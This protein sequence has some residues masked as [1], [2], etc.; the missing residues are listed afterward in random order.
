MADI[1]A[2]RTVIVRDGLRYKKRTQVRSRGGHV[3][4]FSRMVAEA[5]G[6]KTAHRYVRRRYKEERRAEKLFQF[7]LTRDD[8]ILITEAG[9][10]LTYIKVYN[11]SNV[12][13]SITTPEYN[14]NSE[15]WSFN[16][17]DSADADKNGYWVDYLCEDGISTQY[18]Y[19]YKSADKNQE[20]DL[21]KV[22]KY[23][24]AIP[25]WKLSY[26]NNTPVYINWDAFRG[27]DCDEKMLE[28]ANYPHFYTNPPGPDFGRYTTRTNFYKKIT[29]KSSIP[30]KI[31]E[32]LRPGGRHITSFGHDPEGV[33]G[34]FW[35]TKP[36]PELSALC[37]S[38][39]ATARFYGKEL[40]ITYTTI[41]P[42]DSWDDVTEEYEEGPSI[43]GKTF[44]FK[45]D[46]TADPS[47][48]F[49]S[50][51]WFGGNKYEHYATN[52]SWY[53]FSTNRRE[54]SQFI[55]IFASYD[56]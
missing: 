17:A 45:I 5:G 53:R 11:S 51:C 8:G 15:E 25:Y 42:P 32:Q 20:V 29:V 30:Y 40:D 47:I 4:R 10:L 14:V 24:A 9:G 52:I 23:E 21:I 3:P 56:C 2:K 7:R 46:L 33:I 31:T 54:I 48:T 50:Y 12:L 39:G 37:I 44:E 6:K 49:Y 1:L 18:P 13:L 36:C 28:I 22:G 34:S 26:E 55:N 35:G 38:Y 16:L 41:N 19:R 27:L 43:G